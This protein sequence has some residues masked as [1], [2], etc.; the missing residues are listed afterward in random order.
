MLDAETLVRE[1]ILQKTPTRCR[2]SYSEAIQLVADHRLKGC[3][4]TMSHPKIKRVQEWLQ[5]HPPA[6]S[7]ANVPPPIVSTGTTD[8]EASGEYTGKTFNCIVIN[9]ERVQSNFE[10]VQFLFLV[11]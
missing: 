10:N 5:H 7:S 8:C 6:T 3:D 4:K 1:E 9:Q 11:I 2:H